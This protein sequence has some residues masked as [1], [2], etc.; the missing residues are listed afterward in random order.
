MRSERNERHILSHTHAHTEP[1]IVLWNIVVAN[2]WRIVRQK[3]FS[4]LLRLFAQYYHFINIMPILTPVLETG[5]SCVLFQ[6]I[7]CSVA[8]QYTPMM[9]HTYTQRIRAQHAHNHRCTHVCASTVFLSFAYLIQIISSFFIFF[10]IY[11]DF[12]C[13]LFYSHLYI[14]FSVLLF[15]QHVMR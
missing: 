7:R 2:S 6:R 11:F 15:V 1:T 14:H 12:C 10:S 3:C 4:L 5:L 13:P 8:P 9:G